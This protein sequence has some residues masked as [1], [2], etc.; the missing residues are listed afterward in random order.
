MGEAYPQLDSRGKEFLVL[1]GALLDLLA[2]PRRARLADQRALAPAWQ[3]AFGLVEWLCW[4]GL[5]SAISVAGYGQIFR[6]LPGN[7]LAGDVRALF[8][9]FA[10]GAALLG[11]MLCLGVIR[12]V[13]YDGKHFKVLPEFWLK[14]SA[15]PWAVAGL[16]L[17]VLLLLFVFPLLFLAIR[18]IAW[19]W[20]MDCGAVSWTSSSGLPIHQLW[21]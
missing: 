3:T 18:L 19:L 13:S 12:A 8:G 17:A 7:N 21:L 1:L 9:H 5:A 15:D 6:D 14:L 10:R 4:T 2:H 16:L 20:D 11:I